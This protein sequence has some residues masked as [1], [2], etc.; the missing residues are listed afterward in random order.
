MLLYFISVFKDYV[1]KENNKYL[2]LFEEIIIRSSIGVN[3]TETFVSSPKVQQFIKN[4]QSTFDLVI[5]ESFFQECTVAMGHKYG[6]PVV[7][8][9][10]VAPWVTP[11]FKAANPYDFS[12][13]KDFKLDSGKS[14][15]FHNRLLNTL[16]GLYGLIVEPIVYIP[17]LERIMNKHFQYLGYENRPTMMEMLKNTSLSLIDS[18]VTILSPRPYVPSFIEVP[19]IHIRPVKKISEVKCIIIMYLL[20]H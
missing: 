6:A 11:S 1:W 4:D 20:I 8:I 14:L 12:Y 10:P 17:K 7:N 5:V 2:F 15:N 13:I 18:D 9:I 19:G 3:I 16:L